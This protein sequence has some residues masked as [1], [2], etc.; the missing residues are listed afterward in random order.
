MAHHVV[1][2][3]KGLW[4]MGLTVILMAVS[5]ARADQDAVVIDYEPPCTSEDAAQMASLQQTALAETVQAHITTTYQVDAP[6]TILMTC[7]YDGDFGPYYSPDER[8]IVMPYGFRQYAN[9]EL[10]YLDYAEKP[11][12]LDVYA[13]D[14]FLH[15]LYHEMGHALVD[16]LN[17]PITGREEDAVDELATL[18]LLHTFKDGDEIA[19][20]AA[21]FFHLESFQSEDITDA[22]I[23]GEHALDE[24]RFFNILC[25]V[26]GSNPNK[27]NALLEGLDVDDRRADLCIEDY[28]KR[29]DAW[30]RL[31]APHT[32]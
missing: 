25:L 14:I 19:I 22:E 9:E 26:Y 7:S 6:L 30:D 4:V 8:T 3:V 11:E 24:Q 21:D 27:H 29:A 12:E 23:F 2:F 31:L 5:G 28:E 20:T 16:V 10:A 1:R 13:D 32:N 15:T 18:M 17:L